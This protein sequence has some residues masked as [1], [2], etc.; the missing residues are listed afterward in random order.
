MHV[1]KDYAI[2]FGCNKNFFF[3]AR[4]NKSIFFNSLLARLCACLNQNC[5]LVQKSSD[6]WPPYWKNVLLDHKYSWNL[7][8]TFWYKYLQPKCRSCL[9]CFHSLWF[10]THI[11]SPLFQP[12]DWRTVEYVY[13]KGD[14]KSQ[15]RINTVEFY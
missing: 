15:E 3:L 5:I 2:F 6:R 13:S 9:T 12:A 1:G 11:L 10:L 7:P 8:A 4:V 14:R